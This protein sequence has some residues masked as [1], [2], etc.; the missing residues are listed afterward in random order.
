MRPCE[1]LLNVGENTMSMIMTRS[2]RVCESFCRFT[3]GNPYDIPLDWREG[4]SLI[5]CETFATFLLQ[6]L[7]VSLRV[8]AELCCYGVQDRMSEQASLVYIVEVADGCGVNI[9][10]GLV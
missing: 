8:S 9:L 6:P 4:D 10:V 5:V 1:A 2:L 3:L 7:S